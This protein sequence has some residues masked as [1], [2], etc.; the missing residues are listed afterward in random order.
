MSDF[1]SNEFIEFDW[2]VSGSMPFT[3]EITI[4]GSVPVFAE[5][6]A[7]T[8]SNNPV[9]SGSN[10]SRF[11]I[12]LD[13][14]NALDGLRI[15]TDFAAQFAPKKVLGKT[16]VESPFVKNKS[17]LVIKLLTSVNYESITSPTNL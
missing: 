8:A 17:Q 12:E 4:P 15:T 1:S 2:I 3:Y 16:Y 6:R 5:I 14:K 9:P 10:L 13:R 11:A 7:T